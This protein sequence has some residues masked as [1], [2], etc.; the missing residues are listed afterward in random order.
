VLFIYFRGGG[1]KTGQVFSKIIKILVVVSQIIDPK[2][3]TPPGIFS[4]KSP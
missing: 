2:V 3:P 1:F 4:G